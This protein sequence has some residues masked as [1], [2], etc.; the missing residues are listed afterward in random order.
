MKIVKIL[1]FLTLSNIVTFT[2][3][4]EWRMHQGNHLHTGVCDDNPITMPMELKWESSISDFYLYH[5]TIA[6]S[7][8]FVTS[9]YL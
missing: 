8:V 6:D 4:G 9:I 2:Y 7:K 1:V 5:A 3:A